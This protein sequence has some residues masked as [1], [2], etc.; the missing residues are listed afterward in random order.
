M[1]ADQCH[2]DDPLVS[3]NEKSL[4]KWM[5]RTQCFGCQYEKKNSQVIFVESRAMHFTFGAHDSND[6]DHDHDVDDDDDD[7]SMWPRTTMAQHI[8][9]ELNTPAL[10][11]MK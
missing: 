7:D 9:M 5:M 4:L 1:S 2:Y 11:L 8:E 10:R 3:M 6:D